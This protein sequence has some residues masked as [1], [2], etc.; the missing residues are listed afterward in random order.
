MINHL[1]RTT[2]KIGLCLLDCRI[3]SSL[4]LNAD[5][6]KKSFSGMTTPI[7]ISEVHHK[8]FMLHIDFDTNTHT[9]ISE[10]SANKIDEG[11]NYQDISI[12]TLTLYSEKFTRMETV[13][14]RKLLM[15]NVYIFFSS[16]KS[17]GI[18]RTIF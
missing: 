11:D 9:S 4:I 2:A 6:T 5:L 12:E 13:F 15:G 1:K 3:S 10:R 16:W 18:H 17:L 7:I 14:L 8:I